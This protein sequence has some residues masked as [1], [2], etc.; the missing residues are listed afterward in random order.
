LPFRLKQFSGPVH[1]PMLTPT[2]LA[3][4]GRLPSRG[5]RTCRRPPH[6]ELRTFMTT[7]PLRAPYA[8]T[9]ARRAGRSPSR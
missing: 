5:T 6:V 7:K 2:A 4:K 3:A 8:V 1:P 9:T